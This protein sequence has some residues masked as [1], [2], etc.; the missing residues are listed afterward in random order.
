MLLALPAESTVTVTSAPEMSSS[1]ISSSIVGDRSGTSQ[2][3]SSITTETGSASLCYDCA[4]TPTVVFGTP[5]S[6]TTMM[7]NMSSSHPG[8]VGVFP[9]TCSADGTGTT[10]IFTTSIVTTCGPNPTCQATG[11]PR[12]GGAYPSGPILVTATGQDG[13]VNVY[14]QFPAGPASSSIGNSGAR[15]TSNS[16]GGSHPNSGPG[17]GATTITFS[18]TTVIATASTALPTCPY[19]NGAVFTGSMGMQ[20]LINCNSL[21]SNRSL[22]TQTQSNLAS[23]ISSC[24]S[25]NVRTFYTASQC[26]GVSYLLDVKT[27]NCLLK[28]GDKGAYQPNAASAFLLTQ[29]AGPGG[30]GTNPIG[31]TVV[32][33]MTTP[34]L[35]S[36]IVSGGSTVIATVTAGGSGS[37]GRTTIINGVTTVVAGSSNPGGQTTVING[38]PTVIG[39]SDGSGG[40]TTVING[41][42]TVVGGSNGL[43]GD[44][45]GNGV[46]TVVGGS[47]YLSSYAV[48]VTEVSTYISR[49]ITYVSTYGISTAYGTATLIEGGSTVISYV[50]GTAYTATVTT[51]QYSTIVSTAISTYISNGITYTST[52]GVTTERETEFVVSNRVS[53]VAGPTV[54]ASGGQVTVTAGGGGGGA[55]TVYVY[56]SSSS[57]SFT[58]R[59]YATNYLNGM[60]GR[61]EAMSRRKRTLFD[62]DLPKLPRPGTVPMP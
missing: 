16:G 59:T 20:Y 15:P 1:V 31:P 38:V 5:G 58:C 9:S 17:S 22:D 52:Y 10:T 13:S 30:D 26:L 40:K 53:T 2:T 36:Y 32:K 55:T 27:D 19:S 47:T 50:A 8:Y 3:S 12:G 44:G 43:G 54:T 7:A 56:P 29:Y 28:A 23:C 62:V 48:P 49:G 11:Y 42:T 6:S 25:Y 24:D 60:H 45:N 37:G 41:M 39:G 51:T 4:L 14:T 57:T 21:I 34:A 46:T 33:T 35:T 61:R 18:A